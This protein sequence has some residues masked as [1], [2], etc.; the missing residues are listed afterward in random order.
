MS[1]LTIHPPTWLPLSLALGILV[2]LATLWL[3]APQLVEVSGV[4]RVLLPGLR[5]AA[6][7]ALAMSVLR[8]SVL[9]P[10]APAEEGA[11]VILEDASRS[12]SVTDGDRA[13]PTLDLAEALGLLKHRPWDAQFA[14][15][16]TAVNELRSA[17]QSALDAHSDLDYAR[18][19][20]RDS[21]EAQER[22]RA[23]VDRVRSVAADI[24]TKA[25]A[26]GRAGALAK[27]ANDLVELLNASP[28][29]WRQRPQSHLNSIVEPL[30]TARSLVAEEAVRADETLRR[31][32]QV[33]AGMSRHQLAECA[34]TSREAGLLAAL[35]PQTP[36]YAFRFGQTLRPFVPRAASSSTSQPT[37]D[38]ADEPDSDL[39]GALA[40]V[41]EQLRG[42][43]IRAIV[44]LSDG[45]QT[46]ATAAGARQKT[47]SSALR[48]PVVTV[49]CAR[50]GLHDRSII[51]AAVPT[52]VFAGE[53]ATVRVTVRSV[54]LKEEPVDVALDAPGMPREARH[55]DLVAG[56]A[57]TEFELKLM[58]PGVQRISVSVAPAASEAT[59][60]NNRVER[61]VKVLNGKVQIAV[62]SG[63]P[64]WEYQYLRN[65]LARTPF[66]QL[67]DSNLAWADAGTSVRWSMTAEQI[68]QQDVLI[69]CDVAASDVT[70]EQW[71]AV[72][73]AVADRGA[74]VVFL[75]GQEHFADAVPAEMMPWASNSNSSP[76]P[77][78]Q[79][80]TGDEPGCRIVPAPESEEIDSLRLAD[81]AADNR[82]RWT[83]LPALFRY[84]KMP[85]LKPGVRKLLIERTSGNPVLTE[86]RIGSGRAFLLGTDE[87]WRWRTR[88]GERDHD[89]FWLQLVR[90]ASEEPYAVQV[91]GAALDVDPVAAEPGQPVRIRA[92]LLTENGL[93]AAPAEPPRVDIVRP[94]GS[95]LRS[96]P[97]E[98]APAAAGRYRAELEGLVTGEYTLRLRAGHG[99][100]HNEPQMPSMAL[101][102]SSNGEAEMSDL[103]P[104][105][106]NLRRIASASGGEFL[107]LDELRSLPKRVAAVQ[108]TTRPIEY[109]LWDSPYLYFLVLGCLGVEW[110]MRKRAGLA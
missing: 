108:R 1:H 61:L 7:A 52:S 53:T 11:I 26:L 51:R 25:A 89:R 76:T 71:S 39:T 88:S 82:K 97:L 48:A 102:I 15:L 3:Y 98:P 58:T 22:D 34:L 60:Q 33:I 5:L 36:V 99:T 18:L 79:V 87:T 74:S 92:R 2:A 85:P 95:I 42:Q 62:V 67:S 69:F 44:L 24:A 35:D 66:V 73:T 8:P 83:E 57:T 78:W 96:Q 75:L 77:S 84:V 81:S 32:S 104:D 19:A 17:Q 94:D 64:T 109:R 106:D 100:S 54:G 46:A 40:E 47:V 21:R 68:A 55:V 90:Y 101:S 80:S 65:A 59:E 13:A 14:P 63:A 107:R 91:G 6:V 4:R 103:L 72:R 20:G 37:K 93:P 9:R 43:D 110:A 38:E 27:R 45:R 70:S 49:Q 10:R 31:T 56:Q 28:D 30:E 50:G 86:Q 41:S 12:M 23:A 29:E 16:R 105:D